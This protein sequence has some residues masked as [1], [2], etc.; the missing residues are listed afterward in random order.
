MSTTDLRSLA[1]RIRDCMLADRQRL[2]RLLRAAEG[3]AARGE[4]ADRLAERF[5]ADLE[6]SQARL[7]R[8][9][10][11]L[12]RPTWPAELPVVARRADI[13]KAIAEH[14][15]VVLCG[16][17]GSGKTTQLPKIC[18]ELGRGV[19]GLIGHTQPRRIAARTVAGRIAEE[20]GTPLGQAVGYKVRFGDHTGPDTYIKVMTDGI[21]L[22]ETQ[23]DRHLEQYDTIIIDE[24]HER[25]LNI[26]F[27]LGCLRQLL[28]RRPDLKLIITSATIDP[29]RFA[30]HFAPSEHTPAPI[31]EV[32]GRTYPV[33][34]RYRPFAL[35]EADDRD[36]TQAILDAVD[37][38]TTVGGGD[39]LV[40]LSG[41][42]EIRETAEALRKHHPPS[43]EILPLYA[44]LSGA[45][46]MR[47]FQPHQGRRIVLATNVAE[48]SLT[49]PGI[50]Y[51]IDPGLARVSRY[52]HRTK[53]QRLP[54]EAISQASADQ[55]KG[56]CGRVAE[57]VC[58]RL[59]SELDFAQRAR[60]T[61]PEI[62]RTNLA[63]VILQMKFL[64]L[65]NVEEFPFVEPPDPRMVKDGY[66]TLVELGAIEERQATGG[67]RQT[68]W[69]L[70][71][72]GAKLARLPVDP[73]IG[74]MILEAIEEGCVDQVLI[75]AAALEI[76]DPR[77]RP[78]LKQQAADEAHG[79]WRDENSDFLSLL[80]LWGEYQKQ[81]ELLSGSRL[82][83]WCQSNFLSS[84]RMREWEDVHQQLKAQLADM[85][86]VHSDAGRRRAAP[87][88]AGPG[89]GR[90][91][92]QEEGPGRGRP[93]SQEEDQYAA[94]H[95]S[96][97]SGLLS[98]IGTRGSAESFE[99][100][101]PRGSKF[102]IFPGSGL[103]KKGPRWVVASE[104]VQTTKLYART[105]AKIEPQW[106]EPLAAHIVKRSHFDPHWSKEGGQAFAFERV[107]LF[108]LEIVSRKRVPLGPIDPKTARELF[109][110]HGLVAGDIGAEWKFLERNQRLL[111]E[112][113][114][115]E[116]KVRKPDLLADSKAIFDFYDARVP[117]DVYG[118]ATMQKWLRG[119][120]V[121]SQREGV[122]KGEGTKKGDDGEAEGSVAVAPSG[123][124]TD[125]LRSSRG[126]SLLMRW[127]DLVHAAPEEVTPDRYPDVL[128]AAGTRLNLQ[129]V[130]Q[131]GEKED[132]VTMTVPIEA[133]L[134]LDTDKPEWL[135][136]GMLKE[137]IL[138]LF[139][140]LP[141]AWR[142]LMDPA[143]ELA[144]RCVREM[145]FAEGSLFAALEERIHA[146]KGVRVP[147]SA[148]QP[149]SIPDHFRM[150]FRVVDEKGKELAQGRDLAELR[151]RLGAKAKA[152][153]GKLAR[154]TLERQGITDWD[155]GELRERVEVDRA[156]LKL[157]AYPAIADEEASVSLRLL[158]SPR[159]A[160]A[161][162]RAGLLRLFLL[163]SR[164]ELLF[165]LRIL[166]DLEQMGLHYATLGGSEALCADLSALVAERAFM[167]PVYAA[168][169]TPAPQAIDIRTREQF[170]VRL[171]VG[172]ARLH[173][174]VDETGA[175]VARIL[176][177]RHMLAL[178]LAEKAPPAW[179]PTMADIR[180][181]LL[182]LLP[183]GFLHR[184]PWD[185]LRHFPRY[186][187]AIDFRLAKF[188]NAGLD[189][190]YRLMHQFNPYWRRYTDRAAAGAEPEPTTPQLEALR[191]YRWLAEEYR[192]SLFAQE[193]GTASPVSPKR[194]DEL[195][196]RATA[197]E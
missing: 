64:R 91:G 181:Q 197:A 132:G 56:R 76:Q 59:Y 2:V 69:V 127:E 48:T 14:Q 179:E 115:V 106:I 36:Q 120:A 143:P 136:P 24:A 167:S 148:W 9:R 5:R 155:F 4:P 46:Q 176:A 8:R 66:D 35:E 150:N 190:D 18:L 182:Y 152:S 83:K 188:S 25:S 12:P 28:A 186:L 32:S 180:Q 31:I 7:A 99:Y 163:Q 117:A 94:I 88:R 145:P 53:V 20:L 97:L 79:Q 131:P 112:V 151:T 92:S 113:R 157:V 191:A 17:T 149:R 10:E 49:V 26:D 138:A 139:R 39:V 21:L 142:K 175:L 178:R 58:I 147:R 1:P 153:F 15:V 98:S 109:I 78:M 75:I 134:A 38:L 54:I 164:D 177:A 30:R 90:P 42:R 87:S 47:A 129:Y 19:A 172:L 72:M 51:V 50:R 16:E 183:K 105:V 154:G 114:T 67:N 77:E 34:V 60:F 40:F 74:R 13:A 102:N 23:T 89:R 65:G 73:R 141:K 101:G 43:T 174:I 162:T 130:Y 80:K 44:R 133:L 84:M 135:V 29:E 125:S 159:A 108:G 189:R 100:S 70:A 196:A 184:V 195:W 166:P 93:G 57:G 137:K 171:G 41:E 118:V 63:S 96:L 126:D 124:L 111:A 86:L 95:R 81:S 185:N 123:R 122:K 61:E 146:I 6:R 168:G 158:D 128:P 110:H 3:R 52:S 170:Q 116:A 22:A 11:R 27:L 144:E 161:A 121:G 187:N 85:G 194:L 165:Q 103:F 160:A 119:E 104:L 169:G 68:E 45:E 33:E 173:E 107:S 37:E 193:L 55:R 156:G 82:R 62:L 140:C 192:V 71:P